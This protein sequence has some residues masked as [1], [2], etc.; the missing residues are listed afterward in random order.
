MNHSTEPIESRVHRIVSETLQIPLSH[1]TPESTI[2]TL[3]GDSLTR[4]EVCMAMED[5]F[6]IEVADSDAE[7]IATVQQ[8]IDYLSRPAAAAAA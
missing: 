5:E 7:P 8:W 4:V 1:V 6:D 2:G 3:G